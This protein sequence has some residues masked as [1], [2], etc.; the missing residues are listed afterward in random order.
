MSSTISTTDLAEHLAD[1]LDRVR[2]RGEEFIIER[3]GER[4]ARLSPARPQAGITWREFVE[5]LADMPMPDDKFAEDVRAIRAS[6]PPAEVLE[7]PC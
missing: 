3:D 7:W 5:R 4:I 6:Q 1:V 2:S